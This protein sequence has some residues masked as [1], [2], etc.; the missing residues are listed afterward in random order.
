MPQPTVKDQLNGYLLSWPDVSITVKRVRIHK[1][2]DRVT[3]E[4][5]I[6]STTD[7]GKIITLT[8]PTLF[9]FSADRTRKEQAKNL[10]LKYPKL[11]WAEIIDQLCDIV[12][13][14]ARRGEPVLEL[15]TSEENIKPPEPL[16]WPA[17][18]VYLDRIQ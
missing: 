18:L 2:D 13:E 8:P 6:Q 10:S 12:Q 15:W 17:Y 16:L 3:G 14:R 4:I 11:N 5:L 9:N 7:E 1:S